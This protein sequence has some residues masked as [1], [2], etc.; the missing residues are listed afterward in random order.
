MPLLI[1]T[2]TGTSIGKTYAA[3][4]LIV[5]AVRLGIRTLG[6]KPI[7]SGG[8]HDGDTLERAS[9]PGSTPLPR[10]YLLAQPLSAHLA[11]RAENRTIDIDVLRATL[12]PVLQ[13][14]VLVILELPGGLFSPITDSVTNHEVALA[15]HPDHV[16]LVAPD[17]LGVLHDVGA[18]TR[19]STLRLDAIILSAPHQPDSSTGLNARELPLVTDVPCIAT[20][21]RNV[22]RLSAIDAFV[23]SLRP[24]P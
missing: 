13:K 17:R 18:A 20:L 5:S 24:R 19:A 21:E 9:S 1:V 23:K 3:H 16:A 10:P 4:I 8:T 7:E 22:E 12:L 11:A 2:G 6:W 15:L 14:R